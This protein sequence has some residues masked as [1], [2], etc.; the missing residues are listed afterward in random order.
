MISRLVLDHEEF[1]HLSSL[2][3]NKIQAFWLVPFENLPSKPIVFVNLWPS[4]KYCIFDEVEKLRLQ[5][6]KTSKAISRQ[7]FHAKVTSLAI[8]KPSN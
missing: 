4:V 6:T 5:K 2:C 7:I 3:W 8:Y 1:T